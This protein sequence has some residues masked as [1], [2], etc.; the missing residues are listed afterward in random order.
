MLE[1]FAVVLFCHFHREV[2]NDAEPWS[3]KCLLLF[4]LVIGII[5]TC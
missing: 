1:I 4:K 5:F 2:M 3:E